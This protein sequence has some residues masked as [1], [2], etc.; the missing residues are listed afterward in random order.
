MKTDITVITWWTIV[1]AALGACFWIALAYL[2]L[3]C[4]G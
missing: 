4:G 2:L 3:T 1:V